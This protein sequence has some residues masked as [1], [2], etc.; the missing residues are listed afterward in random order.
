[1]A[2]GRRVKWSTRRGQV[3]ELVLRHDRDGITYKQ[4]A[5]ESGLPLP[6]LYAWIQ[7][8]QR[9]QSVASSAAAMSGER[10]RFIELSAAGGVHGSDHQGG[11]EVVMPS[12][13]RVRVD[14]NFHEPTL[15]RLLA[16]LGA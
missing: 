2:D 14:A 13:V 11:I 15:K 3:Q 10:S 16:T 12:G 5:R 7:R 8:L 9:E 6:T 4:I 1:M